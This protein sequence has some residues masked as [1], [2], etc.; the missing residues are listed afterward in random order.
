V[1]VYNTVFEAVSNHGADI[2]VLFV[3][4]AFALELRRSIIAKDIL[5]GLKV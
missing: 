2:S 5:K 4:A 1:P 3:P